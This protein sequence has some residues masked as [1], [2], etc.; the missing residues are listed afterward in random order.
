[1]TPLLCSQ[2]TNVQLKRFSVTA[3]MITDTDQQLKHWD[4][5]NPIIYFTLHNINFPPLENR[6]EQGRQ[7]PRVRK[8]AS[9]ECSSWHILSFWA[10]P[11]SSARLRSQTGSIVPR[12]ETLEKRS[13]AVLRLAHKLS[14]SLQP[15]KA[16]RLP[17]Q[18][19]YSLG[20]DFSCSHPSEYSG[21][22]S[23]RCDRWGWLS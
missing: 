16:C 4:K 3:L 18:C 22:S 15:E 2:P 7:R 5:N 12:N 13:K 9:G 14:L 17:F 6:V 11:V 21:S 10:N 23:M 19:L 20:V 1:M 8:G